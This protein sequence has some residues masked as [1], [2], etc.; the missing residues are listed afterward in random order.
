MNASV[1]CT[2]LHAVKVVVTPSS[3]ALQRPI[4]GLLGRGAAMKT[5]PGVK[6]RGRIE[7]AVLCAVRLANR[8]NCQVRPSG[9]ADD[10]RMGIV[11]SEQGFLYD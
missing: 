6:T 10:G 3:D 7:N 11:T 1:D 8:G 5:I 4:G 9:G 2:A